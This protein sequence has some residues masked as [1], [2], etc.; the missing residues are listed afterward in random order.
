MKHIIL[1]VL[2]FL[3]GLFSGCSKQIFLSGNPVFPGCYADPEGTIYNNKYWI[4]PTFSA[5]YKDQVFMDAF[6]SKDLTNWEKHERIIDTAG[7]KEVGQV[8]ITV[9]H[10]R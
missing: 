3:P 1:M 10:M 5:P 9:S 6:F 2:I 8:Q 4:F 7:R